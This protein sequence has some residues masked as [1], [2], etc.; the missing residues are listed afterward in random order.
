MNLKPRLNY[1]KVIKVYPQ[2]NNL[3]LINLMQE[4][5]WETPKEFCDNFYIQEPKNKISEINWYNA[6][7][8]AL[9]TKTKIFFAHDFEP[10]KDLN[11]LKQYIPIIICPV[12]NLE[13][14]D[15]YKKDFEWFGFE[16]RTKTRTYSIKDF[17]EAT[18]NRKR[19]SMGYRN[20]NDKNIILFDGLDTTIPSKIMSFGKII[21]P[22]GSLY[23]YHRKNKSSSSF[24][25][26]TSLLNLDFY[27]K[28]LW[29]KYQNNEYHLSLDKWIPKLECT[30]K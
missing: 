12:H 15:N 17:I 14:I 10:T 28:E 18:K 22:D 6:L 1:N 16:T 2:E 8:I 27:L 3:L 4:L 9:G 30:I 20:T 23:H 11:L 19:W 25:K 29:I 7:R 5:E 21:N 13:D 24:K 26:I